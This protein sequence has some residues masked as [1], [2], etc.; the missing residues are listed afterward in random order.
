M[1]IS[2]QNSAVSN[3]YLSPNEKEAQNHK[4]Q[5]DTILEEFKKFNDTREKYYELSQHK[6]CVEKMIYK[7]DNPKYKDNDFTYDLAL[8][9]KS[10][11]NSFQNIFKIQNRRFIICTCKMYLEELTEMMELFESEILEFAKQYN[12]KGV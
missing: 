7:M 4:E 10:P 11:H 6:K 1:K 2:T 5:L 9:G 12:L 3:S 8:R